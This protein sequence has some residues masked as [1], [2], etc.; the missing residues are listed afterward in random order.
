M[1]Y[2]AVQATS[3]YR[4]ELFASA[5]TLKVCLHNDTLLWAAYL[6]TLLF[7]QSRTM[8]FFPCLR[9]KKAC[10]WKTKMLLVAAMKIKIR[11]EWYQRGYLF[12]YS[13]SCSLSDTLSEIFIFQ[14][15]CIRKT[16]VNLCSLRKNEVFGHFF[17][18]MLYK[19]DDNCNRILQSHCH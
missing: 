19:T 2:I 7:R 3:K 4:K 13:L 12:N 14:T 5:S 6:I 1:S 15:L 10:E 17:S 18:L 8:F 9:C 16:F 11:Y